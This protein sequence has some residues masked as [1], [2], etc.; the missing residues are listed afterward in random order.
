MQRWEK[1]SLYKEYASLFVLF[2]ICFV[3]AGC[4]AGH[5]GDMPEIGTVHGIVTIDGKHLP[6]VSI[7]FKPDVGRQSIAK[8]DTEGVY[9]A[10]YLIDE[11]GVKVGPCSVYLDWAPDDSGPPIPVKYGFQG[12]L[13]LNVQ[14]GDNTFNIE[15][16]SE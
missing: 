4:G 7:Y 8:T 13:K 16:V 6:N 3:G 15:V 10:M 2:G 5:G 14:P 11:E 9:K 1:M 12:E